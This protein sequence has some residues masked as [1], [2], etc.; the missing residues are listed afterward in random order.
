MLE[1]PDAL[2]GV[3]AVDGVPAPPQQL[4]E[5]LCH[6]AARDAESLHM[7]RVAV[8]VHDRHDVRQAVSRVDDY[9]CHQSCAARESREHH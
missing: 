5:V 1:L 8:A 9:A 2:E 3:D 7:R 6:V 4:R